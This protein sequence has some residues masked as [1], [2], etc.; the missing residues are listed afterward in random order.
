[1]KMLVTILVIMP[2]ATTASDCSDGTSN[3]NDAHEQKRN[4]TLRGV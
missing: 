4:S 1:M 2:V 3:N